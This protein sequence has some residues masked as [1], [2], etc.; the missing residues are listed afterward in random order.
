MLQIKAKRASLNS[1]KKKKNGHN[2][3]KNTHKQT[4]EDQNRRV[5]SIGTIQTAEL[6]PNIAHT[7]TTHLRI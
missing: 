5:T 3:T 2:S 4:M 6:A 1:K 7:F